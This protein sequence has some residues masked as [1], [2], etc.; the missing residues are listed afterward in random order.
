MDFANRLR[1]LRNEKNLTLLQVAKKFNTS[2]TT[3]SNYENGHRKPNL[4]LAVEFATFFNV[5]VDYMLGKSDKRQPEFFTDLPFVR[6]EN[7]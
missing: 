5:S 7:F 1:K 4:D 3:I 2:K 6:Q